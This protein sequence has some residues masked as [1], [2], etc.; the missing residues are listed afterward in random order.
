MTNMELLEQ[1]AAFTKEVTRE[2]RLPVSPQGLEPDAPKGDIAGSLVPKVETRA[3]EIFR[4]RLPDGGAARKKAP[5]ILHQLLTFRDAQLEG[6]RTEGYAVVR[7]IFCVYCGDEQEGGLL[8]LQLMERLR[9]ALL[10]ASVLAG[11]FALDRTAG[12]E[13]LLYPEASAPYY[14][15][16]LVT[17]WKIPSME[18]KVEMQWQGIK[19]LGRPKIRLNRR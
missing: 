5:Y 3:P 7:S 9:V 8:L 15:G 13:G 19:T 6:E 17:N 12:L 4:M 18:R 10:Q 1:L 14:A 2:L 16:E 11:R